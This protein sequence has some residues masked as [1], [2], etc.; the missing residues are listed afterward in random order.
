[1]AFV[2]TIM[3]QQRIRVVNEWYY[4]TSKYDVSP[5]QYVHIVIHTFLENCRRFHLDI[6]VTPQQLIHATGRM[7]RRMYHYKSD[8]KGYMKYGTFAKAF[9][10]PSCWNAILEREWMDYLQHYYFDATY[11]DHMWKHIPD[12]ILDD[13]IPEWRQI[14]TLQLPYTLRRFVLGVDDD[15]ASGYDSNEE[16]EK[17]VQEERREHDE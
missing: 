11:W 16:E 12:C 13:D 5:E 1:M 14:L 2:N 15:D 7:L 8:P 6:N 17:P 3:L 9:R 10:K 4:H